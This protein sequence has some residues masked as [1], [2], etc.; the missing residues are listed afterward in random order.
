[1]AFM[2]VVRAHSVPSGL[3]SH[4][5][6]TSR[7]HRIKMRAADDDDLLSRIATLDGEVTRRSAYAR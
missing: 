2:A 3:S 4:R 6:Q 7:T 1:M 5:T